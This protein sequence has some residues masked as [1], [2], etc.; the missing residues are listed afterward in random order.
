[1]ENC[2]FRAENKLSKGVV[3]ATLKRFLNKK[4]SFIA[5]GV[6]NILL[7]HYAIFRLFVFLYDSFGR[8]TLDSL[9]KGLFINTLLI[10][11]FLAPH[12]LLL[13]SKIKTKFLKVIP[14][15]LYSTFYSLH[16]C[17][18][19][20]FMD[21]YWVDFGGSLY[22]LTGTQE[23]FFNVLYALSWLFMLWA[24][25]S[26]GLFRQSGIEEWYLSLRGKKIKY[27]LAQHGAYTLCRHPIYAAFIAMI[28]TTPHMT[29]DHLFLT[30]SW[31]VY[32][33]WGAGQKE[34]RL[35]RNRSYKSYA[36]QVTAFPFIGNVVDNFFTRI[37]W[38]I[39]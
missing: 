35:M 21:L 30:V 17:L 29:Y 33:L 13:N 31:S 1:M 2:V 25:I 16:S 9:P 18:A 19:I 37:L 6:L 15:A 11:F 4:P 7:F 8:Q 5:L 23:I 39:S 34:K 10:L 14:N 3:I 38:R 22:N 12:S 36:E 32:I 26:T 27:S 24:M 28:W 20:V